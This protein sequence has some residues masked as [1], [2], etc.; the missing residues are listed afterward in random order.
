MA[1]RSEHIAQYNLRAAL[2]YLEAAEATIKK[3]AASPGIGT[4][5]A[6]ELPGLAELRFLPVTRFKNDVIFYRFNAEAIEVIR[7]LHGARD[8]GG[9]LAEDFGVDAE[10]DADGDPPGD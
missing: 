6:P 5:Y 4:R 8:I 2:R 1:D 3:L 7:V 10:Q 9:I